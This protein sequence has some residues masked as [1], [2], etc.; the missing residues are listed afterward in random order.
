MVGAEHRR[1]TRL[2]ISPPAP[3]TST[4]PG[5]IQ[6]K[7]SRSA[8]GIATSRSTNAWT[9]AAATTDWSMTLLSYVAR[10]STPAVIE[11]AVPATATTVTA[12][13]TGTG[14][15][16]RWASMSATQ[17]ATASVD[18][19]SAVRYRSC[20][21]TEP[22]SI[23]CATLGPDASPRIEL[24][25]PAADVDHQDGELRWG[26]QVA[27]RAVVRQRGLLGARQHLGPDAQPRVHAFAEDVG[28]RGVTRRR[29]GAE[30]DPGDVVRV[31]DRGV[32]VDRGEHPHQCLVGQPAGRVDALAQ[33]DDARL[34]HRHL[35]QVADQQLDG[36][37]AAVERR[38]LRPP[39]IRHRARPPTRRPTASSTSSPR[40]FTPGPAASAC[41]ASTCRH[42]T[43]FGMPP[44]EM[45]SISG[46]SPRADRSAR[47]DAVRGGVRRGEPVVLAEPRLHLLHQPR[48]LEGADHRGG[49]RAGQVV[50]RRER[51][52]VRQPRLGGD[53]VGVAARAPVADRVDRPRLA[54][55]LGLD[56]G[57]VR[58]VDHATPS[59]D[60]SWP[61]V[62]ACPRGRAGCRR[63]APSPRRSSTRP[64][65]P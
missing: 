32:L 35:R 7:V 30:A 47:Y 3:S 28:V 13:A 23:D 36:V 43:R 64:S 53:D 59:A 31:Q 56:R 27:D 49:A 37:G 15:A 6:P 26:P 40:G 18:G 24:G 42:F 46:T 65:A 11:S 45:P 2:R 17:A 61:A 25:R 8:I 9:S 48:T 33:P 21:R 51:R 44:A 29:R 5:C 10:S 58:G 41:A 4:R 20:I 38:H 14:Q 60:R 39:H 63:S 1:S 54:P 22:M 50:R 34:P 19:G 12:D 62:R 52:P 55:E 16:S 57:L